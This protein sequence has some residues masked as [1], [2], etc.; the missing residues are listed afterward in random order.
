VSD[1]LAPT[2]LPAGLDIPAADGQH[3][4]LRVR[5]V[6]CPLLTRLEALAARRHQ[7]SA[8]SSRP[9]STETPLN[10]RHRRQPAADRR[11][12]GATPGPLG[13]PHTLLAPT[14]TVSLCPDGCACGQRGLVARTPYHVHQ[15]IALPVMPPAVTHWLLPQGR[16]LACGTLCTA[17]RPEAQASGYGPRLPAYGGEMAGRIGASRRAVQARCASVC[18]SP[19]RKGARQKLVDR[20]SAALVPHDD[21]PGAVARS[22]RATDIDETPG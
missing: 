9:P 15:G 19:L 22:S 18:G 4:P 13:H 2:S 10:R 7:A 1:R 6:V 8:N 20:V 12:P 3:T 16:C 5:L 17:A 14:A 11:T 21:A